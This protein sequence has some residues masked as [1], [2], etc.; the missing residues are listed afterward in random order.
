ME[1]LFISLVMDLTDEA[2][3]G[4]AWYVRAV[5]DGHPLMEPT[6][7]SPSTAYEATR[8]IQEALQSTEGEL[9]PV[10]LPQIAESGSGLIRKAL[11]TALEKAERQVAMVPELKRKLARAAGNSEK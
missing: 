9:P 3:N 8:A 2:P 10:S 7:I 1:R 5:A 11:A 4:P 6:E